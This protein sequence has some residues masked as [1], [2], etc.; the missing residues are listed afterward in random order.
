ML[1]LIMIE[2]LLLALCAEIF[3]EMIF[4]QVLWLQLETVQKYVVTK[5]LFVA[6]FAGV[7]LGP[8]LDTAG[9]WSFLPGLFAGTV[10]VE[11]MYIKNG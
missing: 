11:W 5:G 8:Q 2:A 3:W 9:L 1:I 4:A 7:I 10:Y 6:L